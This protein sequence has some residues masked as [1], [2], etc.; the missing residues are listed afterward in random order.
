MDPKPP[1]PPLE[2]LGKLFFFIGMGLF[3]VAEVAHS[4]GAGDF[5]GVS[6]FLFLFGILAYCFLSFFARLRYSLR[7]LMVTVLCFGAF[8]TM[9][10]TGSSFWCCIGI[11]GLA[12]LATIVLLAADRANRES[13]KEA[14]ANDDNP[15]HE[16]P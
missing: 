14:K 12:S 4:T 16:N 2:F 6:C 8:T 1:V 10:V 5:R 9:V 7:S 11:M 3:L 13:S 15:N